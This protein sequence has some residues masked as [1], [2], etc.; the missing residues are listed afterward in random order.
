MAL[1]PGPDRTG[2]ANVANGDSRTIGD[3]IIRKQVIIRAPER[4]PDGTVVLP[5]ICQY[6]KTPSISSGVFQPA[7]RSWTG[8]AGQVG[9]GQPLFSYNRSI[10]RCMSS[11]LVGCSVPC[12][13]FLPKEHLRKLHLPQNFISEH[14]AAGPP[15][16]NAVSGGS[17]TGCTARLIIADVLAHYFVLL[18][19]SSSDASRP[20]SGFV[21]S[22]CYSCFH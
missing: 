8:P 15:A 6:C 4:A 10:V 22:R 14:D 1:L 7:R 5:Q 11:L 13:S 17:G 3:V 9:L 12:R 18:A 16:N 20:C 2:L 21:S 19:S